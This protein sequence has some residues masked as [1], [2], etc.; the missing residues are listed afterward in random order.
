MRNR[1]PIVVA[2]S[3]FSSNVG[4][5]TLMCELLR[6]LP[7]WE[8]IKLT[9]GHYRS[10]GRDPA[11]CCVSNLLRDEPVIRSGRESN[12]QAGKDTGYFWDAGASNV[13]WVIVKDDQVET[14]INEALARVKSVGVVI[15]G[16]SFLDYVTPELAVMCARSEGGKVKPSARRALMK[17]DLVYLSSLN[18]DAALARKQFEAWRSSLTVELDFSTLPLFTSDDLPRFISLIWQRAPSNPLHPALALQS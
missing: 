14:G 12:Y 16:N 1:L 6:R 15:E 7:G 8:A 2:V 18:A 17:S 13:H 10:C 9:R 5:T 4:K 11:G 3:G